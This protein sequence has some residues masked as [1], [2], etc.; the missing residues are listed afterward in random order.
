MSEQKK[1]N[2]SCRVE[3]KLE[4]EMRVASIFALLVLLAVLDE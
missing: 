4:I 3:G 1:C 2:K